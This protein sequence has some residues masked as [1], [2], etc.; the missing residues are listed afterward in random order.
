MNSTRPDMPATLAPPTC[1][2][3]KQ[4]EAWAKGSFHASSSRER[5]ATTVWAELSFL[6]SLKHKVS[7]LLFTLPRREGKSTW[8][9]S[10]S[11]E[12]DRKHVIV[13]QGV[14]VD[15]CT[16]SHVGDQTGRSNVRTSPLAHLGHSL[17]STQTSSSFPASHI[18]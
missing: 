6:G 18:R 1:L 17:P 5:T 12:K 10:L 2:A 8:H 14:G 11:R 15:P 7:P 4:T 13:A 9:A 16:T 3:C